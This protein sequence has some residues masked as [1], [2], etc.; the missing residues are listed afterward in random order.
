MF[1][2]GLAGLDEEPLDTE[3]MR[4]GQK[5]PTAE[6]LFVIGSDRLR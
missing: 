3:C 2:Y 6:L 1:E 4:P 5:G